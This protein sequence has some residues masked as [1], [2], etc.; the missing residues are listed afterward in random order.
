MYVQYV[1]IT[2]VYEYSDLL[3]VLIVSEHVS[4]VLNVMHNNL[5]TLGAHAPAGYGTWS[6]CVSVC[7]SG[8]TS[9]AT[10]HNGAYNRRYLRLQRNLGNILNMA[11]S[12]KMLCSKVMA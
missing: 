9:P 6:V 12:L 5:L 2:Y 1:H 7:V 3:S 11:F 4:L 8:T 10:M